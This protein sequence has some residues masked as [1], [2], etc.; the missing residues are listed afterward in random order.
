MRNSYIFLTLICAIACFG[1]TAETGE[2]NKDELYQGFVEP[3]Q[4]AKPQVW[5]HWMNGNIT[6]DG[7]RKDLIW[8]KNSGIGGFHHFDVDL[9]TEQVVEKRL[10]YMQDDWKDAFRY[11]ISLADS[12]GLEATI[13]SS[14]GWS[15]TG[16]PWV[17]PE[18]AMKKLTWREFIVDG[19]TKQTIQMPEPYD[20]TGGFQNSKAPENTID[21]YLSK[22]KEKYYE[23]IAV[24]AVKIQ[25]NDKATNAKLTSSGGKFTVEQ[26]TD[27]NL[28]NSSLLPADDKNGF[29]WIQY[30][31]NEPTS[32]KAVS[33]VDGYTRDQFDVSPGKVTKRLEASDDGT[34][35]MLVCDVPRGNVYQQTV[36]FPAVKAKYFRMTFDNLL[37]EIVYLPTYNKPKP[38]TNVAEFAL[39]TSSKIN[40]A[41]EK[42]GFAAPYDMMK[43]VTADDPD[44]LP[45]IA[46][47]VDLTSMVD[48]KGLLK[49]DVP[50]GTWKV[51]RF[52]CS[53][54]G[55]ENGPAPKEATGLEVDKLNAE[56]VRDY[57][58]EYI[59]MYM[60]AS[61]GM[62]GDHGLKYILIDSYEAE[63]A[64]WTRKMLEEFE[65][66]RGYSLLPW[67]PVLTGQIIGSAE[68][69]E[70]FLWDWR[71][72]LGELVSENLYGQVEKI[73][74]E[75]GMKCY[76]EG[77][78]SQRVYITDGMDVKKYA[79][80][81]MAAIWT[82][83]DKDELFNA[84]QCDIRESASVA[85]IYGQNIVAAESFTARGVPEKAYK[86][87]PG[88]LKTVAD[89]ELYYGLNR[90]V[91]HESA[92]Q[93][94]DD[95]RPGVGLLRFGQWFT[96][97]E[98]WA[99]QAKAWMDYL[100]RSSYMM[101]Q[102]KYVADI[103][104][105]Y[106]EDNCVVGLFQQNLPD[107]PSGYSFDYASADVILNQ[108]TAKKGNLV[109][110]TGMTYKILAIDGNARSMSLPVLRKIAQLAKQGVTICGQV[111]E[112]QPSLSGD[113]AEFDKLVAEVWGSGKK[114]VLGGK[115]AGEA[116]A[117]LGIKPD[118][119][120]DDMENVRFVHRTLGGAEIYW[121][122]NASD[123]AKHIKATFRTAGKKPE[124]W[125]PETGQVE[126]LSYLIKDGVTEV[127]LSLVERD[128][129]FIVFCDKAEANEVILQ[130]ATETKLC[131]IDT[132]WE[133]TFGEKTVT[134]EQLASY[135]ELKDLDIKYFS[136]TATYRNSFQLDETG[137]AKF[138]LNLGDVQCIAEVE[139]N[140]NAM[141]TLW[142]T[143][144]SVDIT[145]A[146]K[147]GENEIVVKV[148]NLWV[149]RIIG[150][151]QPGCKV[152]T[153]YQPYQFY[154]AGSRL[155]PSGLIGPV[156]LVVS[157]L[158]VSQ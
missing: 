93:P 142:K 74:E 41:E 133:V 134:F 152:K 140:G 77:H 76:F 11:A 146:V 26:L 27:G 17:K 53:L 75:H 114:N 90:F 131:G 124:L 123:E 1:C 45:E 87:Y 130:T 55:K 150:D 105:F 84:Y 109:T 110:E 100:G 50:E 24:V 61:G 95:K 158:E 89:R 126:Q 108:I 33:V 37:E 6:K 42:A 138:K 40:H 85:H 43:Y 128:A 7:I 38:G 103:L 111:P 44:P 36:S 35:W 83:D 102:G 157:K 3:P 81:P 143:P 141:G 117:A 54:T 30:E 46:D 154:N 69:S 113:K 139:V 137:N 67:M 56:A 49:W 70:Q 120:A 104:Y 15:N 80:F 148:T 68:K 99:A 52:G 94:L 86:Y 21:F 153:T 149:N 122:N 98:T 145:Q 18:N 29:A 9:V 135:T 112:Y 62:M 8:M 127:D 115:S 79:A 92:H 23:D 91:I 106:G 88:N 13:A 12:L 151:Q 63:C 58:N 47:V 125:H 116:L 64:N 51:Y 155:L 107:I 73:A 5:W 57:M 119:M 97:H 48:E 20:K 65:A 118:F 96:R 34:E 82:L 59:N 10:I 71:K 4:E 2:A 25:S 66:R 121:V 129:V 136:G 156:D 101:Q 14:P 32:V 147:Q 39:Y 19:G 72:T 132:P 16:G 78:E 22:T 60:E 144:Y 28:E 31:F